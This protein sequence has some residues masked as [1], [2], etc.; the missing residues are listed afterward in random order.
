MAYGTPRQVDEVEAYY[1]HI[2]HGHPPTKE[3][4]D[5]LLRR[6]QAIGGLSPLNA[7]TEAEARGLET[8]LNADGGRPVRV[9]LGMKHTHPFIGDIVQQMAQDGIAEAVTLVLA[10]HYSTRSVAEYQRAASDAAREA[11]NLALYHVDFWYD[12]VKFLQ[13]IANRVRSRLTDFGNAEDVM[14]V[15]SAHSLPEKILAAGDPYQDQLHATG[16]AVAKALNLKQYMFAWQSAGR[17]ADK[18]LGPDILDVLRD[19]AANG[20]KNVLL[21]PVGFVSDHLEVLYDVD[22]EAQALA[23]ELGIKLARTENLNADP[24]FIDVLRDVVRSRE[25]AAETER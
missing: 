21:C 3:L 4:L 7:I 13:L 6:Y 2:R 25:T 22:I 18:W 12:N 14:V 10:P 15:F 19:L 11:G 1:T 20:R 8:A 17:T 5:D 9:Y 16:D 23:H 24:A